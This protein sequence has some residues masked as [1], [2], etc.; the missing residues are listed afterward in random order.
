MNSQLACEVA[1][2]VAELTHLCASFQAKYGRYYSLKP[3]SSPEAWALYNAIFNKQVEIAQRLEP[4]AIEKVNERRNQWWQRQDAIDL[5][6]TSEIMHEVSQLIA[7]CAYFEAETQETNWSYAVYCLQVSIAERL[8]PAARQ[9]A[10][11]SLEAKSE[12][13][14]I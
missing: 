11:A 4:Q 12:R 13:Y 8:H 5:S 2:K 9:T 1:A 7:T 6:I 10:L 14:A 3:G